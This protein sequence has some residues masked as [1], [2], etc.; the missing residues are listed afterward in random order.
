MKEAVKINLKLSK[1]DYEI[2]WCLYKCEWLHDYHIA[3]IVG[4]NVGY[5]KGRLK[6]LTSAGLVK[7]KILKGDSPAVNWITKAGIRE[8]GAD[9][10]NVREPVLSRYEHTLGCNDVYVY[11]CLLRKK[12]DGSFGRLAYFGEIV[13]ERDFCANREMKKIKTKSNGQP[14]YV[15]LDRDIHRPDG[16]VKRNGVYCALEFERTPKSKLQILR[17]NVTENAKRFEKQYWV[18]DKSSV[19]K[20]LFEMQKE[21]GANKLKVLN[22]EKIRK[23]IKRYVDNLPP[24]ISKKSGKKRISNLGNLVEPTPLNQLPLISK[25]NN[26]KLERRDS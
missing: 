17:Q 15:A 18:Y 3:L 4:E 8:L 6:R 16:Y 11:F 13:T 2:L 1:I 19:G 5:I 14:I 9:M 21:I 26:V 7:R 12:K 25:G 24:I 20:A 23:V 22:I 10:R